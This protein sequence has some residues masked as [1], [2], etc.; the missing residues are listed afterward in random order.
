M[1]RIHGLSKTPVGKSWEAMI[2]RCY[3]PECKAFARYRAMGISVCEFLRAS[4]LNLLQLLGPR[5][6]G[7]SLDRINNDGH[8]SCGKCAECL[9]KSWPTN[10]R[11][12]TRS[13]QQRNRTSNVLVQ[14]NG[15]TQCLAA[16]AEESGVKRC[17]VKERWRQGVRGPDL[18]AKSLRFKK[19]LCH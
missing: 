18:I 14:L 8:Y 10:I 1:K 11:W 4:P 17:T 2:R 16:W 3:G 12:A 19:H 9:Q 13:Q 15:K 5:P 6:N 7:R